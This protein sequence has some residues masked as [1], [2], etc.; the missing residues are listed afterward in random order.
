MAARW[1]TLR[2][3]IALSHFMAI[4]NKSRFIVEEGEIHGTN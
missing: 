1:N 3:G 2:M 4:K